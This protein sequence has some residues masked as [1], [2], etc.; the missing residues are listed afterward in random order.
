MEIL[1]YSMGL[2]VSKDWVF[3]SL[4]RI[5]RMQTVK[6]D[7]SRKF[8]NTVAGLKELKAWLEKNHQHKTVPLVI[9]MEA[10]GVYHE[11][12]AF[13]LERANY[14]VSIIVPTHARR[15]MQSYGHHSKNDKIDAEGLARFGAERQLKQW[16]P[17]SDFY[18]ELRNLTRTRQALV[19]QKTLVGN[20]LHAH[21]IQERKN[22]MVIRE[23]E[24]L[25]SVLD[26]K[27][28]KFDKAIAKHVK[29]DSQVQEKV[30]R[31][32]QIHGVGTLTVATIIAETFGFESFENASQLICYSGLDIIENQSGK[33][34][35]KTR[36][37]K[38]GNPRIRRALYMPS[39][40]AKQKASFAAIYERTFN[41]H[42]IKMKSLVAVQR[43]LLLTIFAL[44]KNGQDY[45]PNIHQVN[46]ATKKS[47]PALAGLQ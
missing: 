47:S 21:R 6:V 14:Y 38:T 10:T 33:S 22:K 42:F 31:I 12:F 43:K 29:S 35:G 15:F 27:I 18:C 39:L 17:G 26:K 20:Q 37:S 3:V 24:N 45:D 5:D 13:G 28:D 16:K 46:V 44:W 9:C 36:I 2:D 4:V 11:L 34:L 40:K 1:K 25:V 23:L 30:Q 32:S 19:E 7:A 41:K 8:S